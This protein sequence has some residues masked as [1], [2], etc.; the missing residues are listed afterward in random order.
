VASIT[1]THYHYAG[2]NAYLLAGT[3]F[4]VFY[5]DLE[6]IWPGLLAVPGEGVPSHF[7]SQWRST[8]AL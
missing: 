4:G 1:W 8:I 5:W 3:F 6:R 7:H 2:L